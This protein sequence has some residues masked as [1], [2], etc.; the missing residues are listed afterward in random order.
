MMHSRLTRW[1]EAADARDVLLEG[2]M[3]HQFQEN[4]PRQHIHLGLTIKAVASWWHHSAASSWWH[5]GVVE[6]RLACGQGPARTNHH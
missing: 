1:I 5:H 2:A 6:H 3:V 4:I